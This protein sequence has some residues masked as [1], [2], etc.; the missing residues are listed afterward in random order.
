MKRFPLIARV[1]AIA[2]CVIDYFLVIRTG[3]FSVFNSIEV[4]DLTKWI[5]PLTS[6]VLVEAAII[7]T[8][9]V[10]AQIKN[11]NCSRVRREDLR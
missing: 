9:T 10:I 4:T 11:N 6:P 5:L 1:V 8:R 2:M 3:S 7:S